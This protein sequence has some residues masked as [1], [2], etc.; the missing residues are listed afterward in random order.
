MAI[1]L[2]AILYAQPLLAQVPQHFNYQAIV[3]GNAGVAIAAKPIGMRF[4]I[5]DGS[6]TGSVQYSETQL[7]TTNAYGLVNLQVGGGTVVA[8]SFTAITWSTG[9]KFLQI[10]VDTTGSANYVN[11]T[12]VELI[13]VPYAFTANTAKL[14]DSATAANTATTAGSAAT[15]HLADSASKANTANTAT[16]ADTAFKAGSAITARVADSANKLA[17]GQA[18]KSVNGLTGN[19]TL[20]VGGGNTLSST[21]NTVTITGSPGTITGINSPVSA[22]SGLLGGGTSGNIVLAVNYGGD[23]S[24]AT[25]SRSDHNHDG[26][27][28]TTASGNTLTL[29]TS[30]TAFSSNGLEVDVTNSTSQSAGVFAQTFSNNSSSAA[31]V[32]QATVSGGASGLLGI[33]LGAN[34]YAVLA[35]AQGSGSYAGVFEGNVTVAGTLSKS[36]GS[37][38]IDHPLDPAGKYLS[39]SFVESPDMMNIYN[40]NITLD[41]GGAATVALPD[42]FEALNKDFRYQ[43]TAI[44]K[45]SPNLYIA[46]EISGN[47]FRIAGGTPGAKVSWTVTGIRHDAYANAH[48]IPVEENKLAAEKGKYIHPDLFGQPASMAIHQ[49]PKI[50]SRSQ[51]QTPKK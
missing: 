7:T 6:A 19:V 38:R 4:S 11:L 30:S 5:H 20:A 23:G 39:H 31:V 26:Q 49:A 10:E 47:R 18:V 51:P 36:A 42:W 50:Q 32:G 25:V 44:G 29:Q 14:A 33:A 45:P 15:A 27:L 17:A 28:W 8:G 22:T 13:A 35:S 21:G 2:V 34:T 3:R 37:F 24:A 41:A 48:R 16:S 40:G 9:N 43:L 46:Q 1:A 12:T